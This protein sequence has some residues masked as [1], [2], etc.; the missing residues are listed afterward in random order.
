MTRLDSPR[1]W[2]SHDGAPGQ[3]D[4]LFDPAGQAEYGVRTRVLI[5]DHVQGIAF[6]VP[7]P[8]R[9]FST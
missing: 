2:V 6:P 7:R 9:G 8:D 1:F 3:L 5:R 4:L